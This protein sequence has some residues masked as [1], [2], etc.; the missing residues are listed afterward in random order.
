[1][2]EA[3]FFAGVS[4]V[5]TGAPYRPEQVYYYMMHEPFTPAFV[6]DISAVW[7]RKLRA[8]AAYE[9]QF[10]SEADE[11]ATAL[12]GQGFLHS[13]ETRAKWFGGMIGA[14]YGEPYTTYG[15]LRLTNFPNLD[16]ARL[17]PGELPP[18]SLYK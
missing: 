13:I 18:Y 4:K 16:E 7:E 3:C 8:L 15:P 2:R 11:P 5:G 14:A 6:L 1:V 10:G 9:S 17:P 12:S